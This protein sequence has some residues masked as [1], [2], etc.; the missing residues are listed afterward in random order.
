MEI[1]R[2]KL[3]YTLDQ[4]VSFVNFM[5]HAKNESIS[6]SENSGF[7]GNE[8]YYKTRAATNARGVLNSKK[9][10]ERWIGSGE[11][12]ECAISAMKCAENLVHYN[13]KTKFIDCLDSTNPK[14]KEDGE[15]VLYH[16][17]RGND[18]QKAFESA[19]D[20]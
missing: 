18:D 12:A 10:D 11:I 19:G 14:Y 9:W 3:K 8:E 5:D 2:I 20:T 4:F 13:Q 16:I 1:D 17:Y 15:K 7:L 6:F